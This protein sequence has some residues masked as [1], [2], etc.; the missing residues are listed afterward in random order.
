MCIGI[1]NFRRFAFFCLMK[2]FVGCGLSARPKSIVQTVN[3][4]AGLVNI[5]SN[6]FSRNDPK[7]GFSS[8]VNV[9]IAAFSI[10][11]GSKLLVP[12]SRGRTAFVI[13]HF[14]IA[15]RWYQLVN[16]ANLASGRGKEGI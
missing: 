9:E 10:S 8:C 11:S 5:E 14:T 1:W 7:E 13:C 6:Q 15:F 3:M 16:M 12:V 2:Q 4:D